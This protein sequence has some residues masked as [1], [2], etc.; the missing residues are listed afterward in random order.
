MKGV[1]RQLW[2]IFDIGFALQKDGNAAEV[3]KILNEGL[4]K[5]KKA[6]SWKKL[7]PM[8]LNPACMKTGSPKTQI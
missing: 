8:F 6:A 1:K 3:D 2:E 7:W 5:M 4:E